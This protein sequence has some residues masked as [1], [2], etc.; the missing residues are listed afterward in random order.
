MSAPIPPRHWPATRWWTRETGTLGPSVRAKVPILAPNSNRVVGEVSVGI[1]TAAVHHQLWTDVR[2]AA[3]L[4][5]VA[6]I[7]GIVGSVFWPDGGGA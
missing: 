3:V 2:T 1:S 4:V 5:G 7:I 6:L